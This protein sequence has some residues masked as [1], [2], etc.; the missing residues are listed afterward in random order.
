MLAFVR[1][2]ESTDLCLL[3]EPIEESINAFDPQHRPV[4]FLRLGRLTCHWTEQIPWS[5]AEE[6]NWWY[7]HCRHAHQPEDG[8][9]Q[10]AYMLVSLGQADALLTQYVVAMVLNIDDWKGNGWN[11]DRAEW[12][13]L[14]NSLRSLRD[15]EGILAHCHGKLT[16]RL[17][18]GSAAM[19]TLA[20][21]MIGRA[22]S[23]VK[24]IKF[25]TWRSWHAHSLFDVNRVC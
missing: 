15:I 24:R 20:K 6:A 1:V 19:E 16:S 7:Y 13:R 14:D 10:L 4:A 8:Y 25:R 5:F 11:G 12:Q 21:A 2:I 17:Q 23:L 22:S 18:L 3:C 9:H